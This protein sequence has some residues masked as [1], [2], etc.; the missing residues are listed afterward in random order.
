MGKDLSQY[1]TSDYPADHFLY[2][3]TNAK[4]I[5]KFKDETHGVAPLEF[6]G[7]QSKMYSL[8]LSG[9][10]EKKTAKGV[11]RSY[12]AKSIRHADCKKCL[13]D[14]FPTISTFHN[15]RSLEHGLHTTKITKAA[16][17]PYDDKRYLINSRVS[18]AYGHFKIAC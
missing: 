18:C 4:V 2:T 10:K 3:L 8:L 11:K 7:L 6:V 16:L 15:I 12:V 14:E 9:E 13:F 5:G 17:S 1:D